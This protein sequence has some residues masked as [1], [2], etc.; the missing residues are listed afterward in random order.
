MSDTLRTHRADAP[1]SMAGGVSNS[2]Q[3]H[4]YSAMIL[5]TS[6]I[7]FVYSG[8]FNFACMFCVMRH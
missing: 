3:V 5:V 7:Y 8:S 4:R 6:S 2:V 1:Q